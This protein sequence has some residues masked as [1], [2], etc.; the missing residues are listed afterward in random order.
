MFFL[1]FVAI[2]AF[3]SCIQNYEGGFTS[4]TNVT[5]DRSNG[6]RIWIYRSCIDMAADHPITGVGMGQFKRYYHSGYKYSEE[7]Q[8]LPHGH[9]NF[10][11]LLAE[12][13]IVG[14][15]GLLGFVGYFLVTSFKHWKKDKNPYDL[16]IFTTVLSY[17][18]LFGQIEYTLDNS[19]GMRIFWFLLAIMLQMKHLEKA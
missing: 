10:L 3:V 13:G 5:T 8:D 18:C 14:V 16:L 1:A 12:T 11:Q 19:S 17:I 7:T 6:D 4:I 9:N 15:I 2:F